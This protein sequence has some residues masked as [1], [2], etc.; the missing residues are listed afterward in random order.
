[1]NIYDGAFFAIQLQFKSLNF[2]LGSKYISETLNRFYFDLAEVFLPL[3]DQI[4]SNI[5]KI[6]FQKKFK[7]CDYMISN[8]TNITN[9]DHNIISYMRKVKMIGNRIYKFVHNIFI[10]TQQISSEHRGKAN[11]FILHT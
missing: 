6:H 4:Y 7:Q 5:S 9:I 10:N 11:F 8:I 3:Y 2:V 1:M